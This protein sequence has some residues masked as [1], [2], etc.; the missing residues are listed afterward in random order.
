[1]SPSS[2]AAAIAYAAAFDA[3][4]AASPFSTRPQ[5]GGWVSTCLVHCDAGDAAW[6]STLAPPRS[7]SGPALT[8]AAAFDAW[9]R[10]SGSWWAD[11]NPTPNITKNC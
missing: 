11:T 9:L 3:S 2:R 7:G 8:P 1:M 10:G 4:L 6:S 5:H